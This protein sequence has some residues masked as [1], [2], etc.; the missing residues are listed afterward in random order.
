MQNPP[1]YGQDDS[2]RVNGTIIQ[3]EKDFMQYSFT[4]YVQ[5]INI[6]TLL[7]ESNRGVKISVKNKPEITTLLKQIPESEGMEQLILFCA[8]CNRCL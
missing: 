5:F 8:F 4:H 3:F 1:E 2:L 7:N 6:N